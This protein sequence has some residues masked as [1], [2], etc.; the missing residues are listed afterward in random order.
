MM[1]SAN[2]LV[3]GWEMCKC[4]GLLAVFALDKWMNFT[5][6]KQLN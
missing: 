5:K 4:L 3:V 1:H 6:I 2:V